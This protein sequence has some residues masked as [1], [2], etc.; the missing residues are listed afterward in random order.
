[1]GVGNVVGTQLAI[2]PD[3][4]MGGGGGRDAGGRVRGAAFAVAG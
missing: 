3:G 1:M 4:M 2:S